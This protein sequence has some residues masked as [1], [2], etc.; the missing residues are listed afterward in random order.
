MKIMIR[1]TISITITSRQIQSDVLKP[2]K[3]E[4]QLYGSTLGR[5]TKY[6]KQV[7]NHADVKWSNVFLGYCTHSPQKQRS[8]LPDTS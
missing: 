6:V 5:G 8:A 7:S 4:Y 1:R 3:A 2:I